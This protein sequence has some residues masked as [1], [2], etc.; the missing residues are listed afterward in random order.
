MPEPM[1]EGAAVEAA[2]RAHHT[3]YERVAPYYGYATREETR[4]PWDDLDIKMRA[5]MLDAERAALDAISYPALLAELSRLR[6]EL[7]AA[8]KEIERLRIRWWRHT[9]V[10]SSLCS[11]AC[12]EMHTYE[13]MCCLAPKDISRA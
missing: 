8:D 2:A 6:E 3:E 9:D 12:N 10:C 7:A 13:G 11:D 5:L 1:E 4:V